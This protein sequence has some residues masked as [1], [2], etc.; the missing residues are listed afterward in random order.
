MQPDEPK[1]VLAKKLYCDKTFS[2]DDICSTLKMSTSTLCRYVA[3]KPSEDA[4]CE[5]PA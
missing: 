5:I 4:G 1:V 2:L 3:T